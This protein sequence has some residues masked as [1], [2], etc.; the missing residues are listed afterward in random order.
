MEMYLRYFQNTVC[1]CVWGGGGGGRGGRGRLIDF[2]SF[3][4][5]SIGF[6]K[7]FAVWYLCV[8]N[9]V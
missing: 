7:C 2:V 5:L 1:V 6:F 8:M 3:H 9:Y 4:D